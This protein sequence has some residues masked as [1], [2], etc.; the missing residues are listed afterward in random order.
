MR[1]LFGACLIVFALSACSF[2]TDFYN[3]TSLYQI[4]DLTVN[5]MLQD[6]DYLTDVVLD[7]SP[8]IAVAKALYGI[9][10][11]GRFAQYRQEINENTSTLD[12]FGLVSK[13]LG[14]IH[15]DHLW[16]LESAPVIPPDS[17]VDSVLMT[18]MLSFAHWNQLYP[19]DKDGN[20]YIGGLYGEYLEGKYFTI[21]D[22]VMFGGFI[23]RGSEVYEI[24]NVE[25]NTFIN[26]YLDY[27][28]MVWDKDRKQ[29][30]L[31]HFFY[32][33]FAQMPDT[34]SFAIRFPDGT[35]HTLVRE[36]SRIS[37]KELDA[38]NAINRNV[39]FGK[40]PA[41]FSAEKVL[42]IKLRLMNEAAA[43]DIIS[44]LRTLTEGKDIEKV[45][46]DIR[47]NPGGSDNAWMALIQ[48]ITGQPLEI[49]FTYGIKDSLYL[50]NKVP[51]SLFN[52]E[53]KSF[54]FLNG[55]TYI[56]NQSSTLNAAPSDN[57][58]FSGPV[59]LLV[60]NIYSSAGSF[61]EYGKHKDNIIVTGRPSGYLLGFGIDPVMF[62]LPNSKINFS[63][64]PVID[65]S[66]TNSA[67]DV[68]HD[69]VEVPVKMTSEELVDMYSYEG[70][71]L[72]EDYL[73]N[74]DEFV[75]TA[76]EQ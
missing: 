29:F 11:A 12:F 44:K 52:G 21:K 7:A 60:D 47:N 16:I 41:Y 31:S 17:S 10:A 51:A 6:Y 28:A 68:M 63:V 39:I 54:S 9:D 23:P 58:G 75:K 46:I 33:V 25:I 38:Q 56:V 14:S 26:K 32:N 37:Q 40:N 1:K 36:N 64:E 73:F 22:Y 43:H 66:N 59:F 49:N 53:L 5:Q 71:L 34:H 72:S 19:P 50:R 45:I 48:Y 18:N 2:L 30:V 74:H 4:P 67:L 20:V 57:L 61:A 13:V 65:L 3:D 8:H 62:T 55:Q 69:S 15:G 42:Y 27:A 24:D 70:D 35:E 76:M